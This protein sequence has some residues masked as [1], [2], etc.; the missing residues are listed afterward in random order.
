MSKKTIAM[1]DG[2]PVISLKDIENVR[3]Q[4]LC[5]VYLLIRGC[6]WDRVPFLCMLVASHLKKLGIAVNIS[7]GINN[8]GVEY[9]SIVLSYVTGLETPEENPCAEFL[10]R[11]ETCQIVD[12]FL[13]LNEVEGNARCVAQLSTIIENAC[14]NL[15]IYVSKQTN[16]KK[17][18]KQ[19]KTQQQ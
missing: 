18:P 4:A 14:Q 11:L 1:K 9:C 5:C 12:E 8:R 15:A 10:K 3:T 2:K 19:P 7:V 16:D 13:V 17:T 6:A